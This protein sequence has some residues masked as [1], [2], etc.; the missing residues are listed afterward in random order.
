MAIAESSNRRCCHPNHLHLHSNSMS[1]HQ[2]SPGSAQSEQSDRLTQQKRS[3][4]HHQNDLSSDD[5]EEEEEEE[6]QLFVPLVKRPKLTTKVE[7]PPVTLGKSDFDLADDEMPPEFSAPRSNS[8]KPAAAA[9]TAAL[10]KQLAGTVRSFESAHEKLQA[11]QHPFSQLFAW[12]KEKAKEVSNIRSEMNSLSSEYNKLA[13]SM[14]TTQKQAMALQSKKTTAEGDRDHWKGKYRAEKN[15][16]SKLK[17][18]LKEVRAR[19]SASPA[20]GPPAGKLA[21]KGHHH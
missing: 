5:D 6:L 10:K 21:P 12:G 15:F 18:E 11:L 8:K 17:A 2:Q 20:N 4:P 14:Q 16:N 3:H 9:L 7:K 19:L 1:Y 13:Q